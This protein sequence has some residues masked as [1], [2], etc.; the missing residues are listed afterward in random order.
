MSMRAHSKQHGTSIT[1]EAGC[2]VILPIL[3]S[4][5]AAA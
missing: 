4:L 5:F 1:S 3:Q 2:A